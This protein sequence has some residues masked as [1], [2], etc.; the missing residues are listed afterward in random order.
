MNM[1]G[2]AGDA[3]LYSRSVPGSLARVNTGGFGDII[4]TL[5]VLWCGGGCLWDYAWCRVGGG[6]SSFCDFH[7]SYCLWACRNPSPGP[8]IL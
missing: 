3:S 5:G 7:F 2:F 6:P 8:I 4:S 1:P